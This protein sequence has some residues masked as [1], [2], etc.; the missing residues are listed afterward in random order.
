MQREMARPRQLRGIHRDATKV[1]N[2]LVGDT[3]RITL[4]AER[5]FAIPQ[6]FPD[7]VEQAYRRLVEAGYTA[8]LIQT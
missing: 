6:E 1:I 4:Y 2:M 7:D 3:Q 5:G 8:R